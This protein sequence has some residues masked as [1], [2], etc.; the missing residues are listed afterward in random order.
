MGDNLTTRKTSKIGLNT[1]DDQRLYVN[2]I[3]SY[4]HDEK[5]YLFNRGLGNKINAALLDIDKDQ[6]ANIILEL[7]INDD[8]TL[9][10]AAIK[11]YNDL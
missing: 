6:L 3:K 4:P 1:F 2:N 7:S 8:R 11:L 9:I 10:L 5:L